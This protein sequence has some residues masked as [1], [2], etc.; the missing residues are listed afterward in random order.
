MLGKRGDFTLH[1]QTHRASLSHTFALVKEYLSIFP[2]M[3][4]FY[5]QYNSWMWWKAQLSKLLWTWTDTL[6]FQPQIWSRATGPA[7]AGAGAAPAPAL[8]Q[9]LPGQEPLPAQHALA[10][11][12]RKDELFTG[13][14]IRIFCC[15]PD[16]FEESHPLFQQY[17]KQ[18]QMCYFH[19]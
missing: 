12:L 4:R 1:I 16:T 14:W 8:S 3:T 5:G 18:K 7:E 6:H 11:A 13:T 17:W 2:E 15:P 10:R 19:F 9:G